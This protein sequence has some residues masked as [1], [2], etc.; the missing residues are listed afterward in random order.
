MTEG[1]VIIDK[2]LNRPKYL[3]EF[4]MTFLYFERFNEILKQIDEYGVRLNMY[5]T[6]AVLPSFALMRQLYRNLKVYMVKPTADKLDKQFNQVSNDITILT[7]K[8]QAPMRLFQALGEINEALV[9]T[10][11]FAGFGVMLRRNFTDMQRAKK[12]LGV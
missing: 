12:A 3:S 7:R 10:M 2:T 6:T 8:K 9:E 1:N 5:D 11:Q 4:N